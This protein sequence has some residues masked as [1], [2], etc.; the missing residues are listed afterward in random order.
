MTMHATGS[1]ELVESNLQ[2]WLA[3]AFAAERAPRRV[4]R[5]NPIRQVARARMPVR[6]FYWWMLGL[7]VAALLL[8]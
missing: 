2:E 3:A 1:I 8:R 4:Y 6:G 7:A 5:E